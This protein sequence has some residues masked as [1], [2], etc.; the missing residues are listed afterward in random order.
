VTVADTPFYDRP[1]DSFSDRAMT[2]LRRGFNGLWYAVL[3]TNSRFPGGPDF[4]RC[5]KVPEAAEHRCAAA[6]RAR[7]GDYDAYDVRWWWKA[8][9]AENEK[10]P[11]KYGVRNHRGMWLT[12]TPPLVWTD[13]PAQRVLFDDPAFAEFVVAGQPPNFHRECEIVTVDPESESKETP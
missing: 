1:L 13:D 7:A 4:C 11:P 10:N 2:R 8:K 12:S 5:G 3:D 6:I 9:W